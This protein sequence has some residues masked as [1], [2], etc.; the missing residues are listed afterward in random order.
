MEMPENQL[1]VESVFRFTPDAINISPD[2]QGVFVFFNESCEAILIGSA[3]KSVR[4]V[5]L[6]HWKGHEGGATCGAVYVG[7]EASDVPLQREAELLSE[8]LRVFGRLPRRNSA[9]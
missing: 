7:F 5:L 4:R 9:A 2:K 6:G 8:H 1:G 3:K